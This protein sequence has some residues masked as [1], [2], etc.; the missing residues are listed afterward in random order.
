MPISL[1][2]YYWKDLFLLQQ[3][4]IDDANFGQNSWHQKWKKGKGSWWAVMAGTGVNGLND[5]K[6]IPSFT[7]W[8]IHKKYT[9]F[10]CSNRSSRITSSMIVVQGLF[11]MQQCVQIKALL[12]QVRCYPLLYVKKLQLP[13]KSRVQYLWR[14]DF[15]N[16]MSQLKYQISWENI[17]VRLY[18]FPDL[19]CTVYIMDYWS[20]VRPSEQDIGKVLFVCSLTLMQ[21]RFISIAEKG[22]K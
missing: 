13:P 1:I 6:V 20:S 5:T 12:H 10:Q 4:S 18:K 19:C 3:R 8:I 11:L 7:I 2:W 22:T 17:F 14:W 15:K 21:S 16:C 9:Q